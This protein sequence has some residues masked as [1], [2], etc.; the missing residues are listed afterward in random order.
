MRY[1]HD[2]VTWPNDSDDWTCNQ[3]DDRLPDRMDS[4]INLCEGIKII[5][6]SGDGKMPIVSI[7]EEMAYRIQDLLDEHCIE[8]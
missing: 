6:R 2:S 1:Y 4:L 3:W 8:R 5:H 7:L